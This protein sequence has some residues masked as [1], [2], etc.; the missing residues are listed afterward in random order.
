MY[1]H[2]MDNYST[3]QSATLLLLLFIHMVYLQTDSLLYDIILGYGEI[4]FVIG[5]YIKYTVYTDNII[6]FSLHIIFL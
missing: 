4:Q 1:V 5:T 3:R 2:T 6:E